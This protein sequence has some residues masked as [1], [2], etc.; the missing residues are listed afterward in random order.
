MMVIC[1]A[2]YKVANL[3]YRHCEARS[4]LSCYFSV[5]TFLNPTV[6]GSRRFFFCATAKGG[7]AL[8]HE[9]Q[10]VH[11]KENQLKSLRMHYFTARFTISRSKIASCSRSTRARQFKMT[12]I[13]NGNPTA[14]QSGTILTPSFRGGTTK[15]SLLLFFFQ[16]SNCTSPRT[17][18][19]L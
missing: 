1:L 6:S 18:S 7:A 16:D 19:S 5:L 17:G 3:H 15:R 13:R 14:L 8:S 9:K 2:H 12:I 11:F 4:N 10:N